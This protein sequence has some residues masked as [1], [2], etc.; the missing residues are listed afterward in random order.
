MD[1]IDLEQY[2]REN[3][4][5]LLDSLSMP[6]N[7]TKLNKLFDSYTLSLASVLLYSEVSY[8]N[9]TDEDFSIIEAITNPQKGDKKD[10]DYIFCNDLNSILK[11]VKKGSYLSPEHSATI[12]CSVDSF[13]GLTLTLKGPG[14][15][16]EKK[17]SYPV[18]EEFVKCFNENNKE[19]PLGNEVV[20]LN[21]QSGEIKS[22]CRTTK[23]ELF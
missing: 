3:F 1:K 14:I 19:F 5:T 4:R 21:K 16:V 23:L 9:S 22:L 10:A 17:E 20:F 12:I 11:E 15:N 13:E 8:L 6:G 2:N 7:T 18:N